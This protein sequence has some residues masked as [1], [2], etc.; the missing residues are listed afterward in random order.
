MDSYFTLPHFD[1]VAFTL[2]PLTVR[3]YGLM[4][5]VGIILGWKIATWLLKN[6]SNSVQVKDFDDS[7]LYFIIG[8]VVGGRLGHVLFYDLGMLIR[9]PLEIFKTWHGGMSFHGGILGVMIGLYIFSVRRKIPYLSLLD[10]YAVVAPVGLFFGRI[11]NFINGE[12]WGR[13]TDVPWAV[14]N[15]YPDQLPRHPSQLYEAFA[16]GIVLLL[17][18]TLFWKR[19]DWRCYPGR[20]SGIFAIG[21]ALARCICELYRV[22]DGYA[23]GSM[24]LGQLLTIPLIGIGWFL[25]RR[26][27]ERQPEC[28]Q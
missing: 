17:I 26:P 14:I 9:D 13:V 27:V 5:V 2:G 21:Y 16:E 28:P 25:L 18:T 1:P 19:S 23:F 4:Y 11:G 12:L 3:W 22:P 6:Y 10:V 8:M 20:I 7:I 24:T 15:I